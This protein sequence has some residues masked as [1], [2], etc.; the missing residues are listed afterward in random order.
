MKEFT[1]KILQ[2][3]KFYP[4]YGGVEKVEFELML[5]LSEKNIRC[6][7]LCAA[8]EGKSKKYEFNDKAKLLT[9]HSWTKAAATMISPA[10]V[11]IMM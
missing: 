9:C 2:L 11:F 6:D 10:M 3:G 5:G 4:I 7:M 1:R 8:L